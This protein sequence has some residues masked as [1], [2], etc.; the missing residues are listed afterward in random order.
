MIP[1]PPLFN[2]FLKL[3]DAGFPLGIDEYRLVIEAV[4]RGFGGGSLEALGQLCRTLWAKSLE[5]QR[6]FDIHFSQIL[7]QLNSITLNQESTNE[8]NSNIQSEP[9]LPDENQT[10]TT[11]DTSLKPEVSLID[12]KFD[13]RT[14][15]V[16][17]TKDEVQAAKTAQPVPV[18]HPNDQE[19]FPYQEFNLIDS[20][21][22]IREREL[23]QSW[24]QLRYWVR[25]GPSIEFDEA[26][27]IRAFART[28]VLLGPIFIPRR[29]NLAELIFL[30]D[31]YGSMT[32]FHELIQRFEDTAYNGSRLGKVTTYYFHN[33]PA[34]F[35]FQDQVLTKTISIEKRIPGI[36][37]KK[38]SVVIISDAGA[39]RGGFSLGRI[40]ETRVFLDLLLSQTQR[41]VWLNPMP[42]NRWFGS[43]AEAIARLVPMFESS[44]TGANEALKL[45]RKNGYSNLKIVRT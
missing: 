41:V 17:E 18:Y 42:R 36:H 10:P 31:R 12:E 24:R 28:G 11:N 35:L 22:P 34:E 25:Q 21:L 3:R 30:I 8:K 45:L 23:K 15:L 27:T 20:Y 29:H 4:G 38:S 43:S 40:E 39:A 32:P 7:A 19:S 16:L 5:E 14:Q 13:Q 2:L 9:K 1:T 6:L 44:R 26:A 33:C 37:R